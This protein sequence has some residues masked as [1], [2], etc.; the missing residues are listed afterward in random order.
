MEFVIVIVLG[1]LVL[2]AVL[3]GYFLLGGFS[4]DP[5]LANTDWGAFGSY[6]GGLAGPL[7]T[8]ISVILIVGN[9]KIW[10]ISR[11]C[12]EVAIPHLNGFIG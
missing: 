12:G 2:I 9:P 1:L 4:L 5:S 11:Y 6:F 10:L 3:L 8:F 7:L